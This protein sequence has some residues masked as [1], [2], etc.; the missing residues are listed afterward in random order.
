MITKD[1]LNKYDG[2]FTKAEK[3]LK[4]KLGDD[5]FDGEITGIEEYFSYIF[6]PT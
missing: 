6:H 3:V 5:K 1:N 2:L 4:K